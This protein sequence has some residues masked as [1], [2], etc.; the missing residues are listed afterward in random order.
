MGDR[1][2]PIKFGP[3]WLRNMPRERTASS[4]PNS[5]NPSSATSSGGGA[6]SPG[7]SGA[8]ASGTPTPSGTGNTANNSGTSKV[9][10]AKLRYGREEMLALYDRNTEA[11]AELKAIETLYQPR[12]KPP[13][14][15]DNTFEEERDTARSVPPTGGAPS[16]ERYGMGRG[17]GRG[18]HPVEGRGR[19][20]GMFIRQT[21]TVRSSSWHVIN[22]R[23]PLYSGPEDDPVPPNRSWSASNPPNNRNSGEQT[24]WTPNKPY[25]NKRPGPNTNWRQ[26]SRDEG[27]EWRA[28]TS[29]SRGQDKWDRDWG[30]RPNQEKQSWNPNRRNWAGDDD[31]LPEWA[32]ENAEAC[33][34]TFDSSG[35]FHGYS[36]DDS[37]L[38]KNQD[39]VYRQ[40]LTR[41][42]THGSFARQ[43]TVEE[44]S[45]EWWA[46]EKAKKL[47]PK[48]F[49]AG[50]IKFK[51]PASAAIPEASANIAVKTLS[52]K[53]DQIDDEES[54]KD[55]DATVSDSPPETPKKAIVP[56]EKKED[57]KKE[58]VNKKPLPKPKFTEV[59]P[60]E[61][62]M[63]SE[64]KTKQTNEDNFKSAM[65]MPPNNNLRQKHQNIVSP[66]GDSHEKQERQPGIL[67]LPSSQDKINKSAENK[68]VDD[69]F[70][71]A[72][73]DK[74]ILQKLPKSTNSSLLAA[75][76][77]Q[78]S[79]MPGGL[80][81]VVHPRPDIHASMFSVPPPM[82]PGQG[83]AINPNKTILP[84]PNMQSGLQPGM[85]Q[86][87]IT[88][89]ALNASLGLPIARPNIGLP[90]TGVPPPM[91]S[92]QMSNTGLGGGA[93][94]NPLGVGGMQSGP[95]GLAGYQGGGISGLGTPNLV[96]NSLFMGQNSNN[97]SMSSPGDI[98]MPNHNNQSN[99]FPM[100]GLQHSGNQ[101]G[102][103]NSIY[104]SLMQHTS[105]PPPSTAHSLSD[106]WYYED[107]KKM[108]QGPFTSKEM[109]NWYRAG[110]FS[111]TLMVRRAC[112]TLMRPLGSY[113]PVVPF[114]QMDMMSYS[115]PHD[116]ML[117]P[118]SSLGLDVESLWNPPS[119]TSDMMWMQHSVNTRNE[120]RVNILPM[121]F[122]DQPSA[123]T[124][125]ALLPEEIAKEMKTEDQI[126]AQ[127]RASQNISSTQVPFLSDQAT[128]S[129]SNKSDFTQT[130]SATPTL[131]EL[132]K[133]MQKES[134][135]ATPKPTVSESSVA[136]EQPKTEKP[137]KPEA[138]ETLVTKQQQQKNPEPKAKSRNENEKNVK[139]QENNAKNKTKKSKDDKKDDSDL[140]VKDDD[141][142]LE[143]RSSEPS[144]TKSKKEEKVNKKDIE[145]E[146][147]EWI[148]EG[149]TIVKGSEKGNNKDVKRKAIEARA[150]EEAERKRKEEE[151]LAA[152][153]EKKK[154]QSEA[155][156]KQQDVQQPPPKPSTVESVAKK[157]PWSVANHTL[158][159]PNKDGLN[160]AEIQRLE[161][162]K[163]LEQMKEQQQ[164]MH[165]IAQQQAVAMAR[166]QE[167]Q[168][169]LGGWGKKKTTLP[170]GTP[171]QTLAEIQ[172]EAKKQAATLAAVAA[173]IMEEPLISNQPQPNHAPWNNSA[174]DILLGG[175]WDT[176][177][178]SQ[179]TKVEKPQAVES[180]PKPAETN[181]NKK[182]LT[183][184]PLVKKEIS[185][186]V[187]FE[188]WCTSALSSWSS[189]V[190][191]PTF[192]GFLK[193]IESPYEVKDYVKCYLGESKDLNDFSRQFLERRSK[194]LRVGMVTPSDDLCSPAIAINPR[195]NSGSDYQEVKGK[196]KKAK[197]NK[198]L[199]V[200]A[201]ILGFSV[202]AS[203]D[204]INVGDIDTV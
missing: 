26:S 32:M 73:E 86:V 78:S 104:N 12:G 46:S 13:A 145:K 49:D 172:A 19:G 189:K 182:K 59:K 134:L 45:E 188:N 23:M 146:K 85:I 25:R 141:V 53:D 8:T 33:G 149:F 136:V 66:V 142:K 91:L 163:K 43:K 135:I 140:K 153:E 55:S 80:S 10:L 162:E 50:D 187:E 99:M 192:V 154:K 119:S 18:H 176:P 42:H 108:I 7:A 151:K 103:F 185:P 74:D 52:A 97:S 148:K 16:G 177:Q 124:P 56:K 31:N 180:S 62:L 200:D 4:P 191:V 155:I 47:S 89:N 171:S 82:L 202:T 121:S 160:L 79:M 44:G 75:A 137:P 67:R 90:I 83:M 24:D 181:K 117:N 194:L 3:L 102:T 132:Q 127:L 158:H 186:A 147:K 69:L 5:Q 1:S 35:A 157:A 156:K 197:K 165:I 87:G 61:S 20:R 29:R 77:Q 204:R 63:R 166:D 92:N 173:S 30:E 17:A 9:L 126:L 107:P 38:P 199:K 115:N 95:T 130:T 118:Q 76:N 184:V 129:T 201:R 88:N 100:H 170:I 112:D 196:G 120:N 71:L 138:V 101:A 98:P 203:E 2:N 116:N 48:R 169:G 93:L 41:S 28:D 139:K 39:N 40:S 195:T 128:T 133:L 179:P 94:Q 183:F 51:K 58:K 114:A 174:N 105:V 96:N 60:F 84:P 123:I 68:I 11:P 14:A 64:S 161:R 57:E 131:E 34:G 110:F 175:F 113:G 37:N 125:H 150:V 122:W 15:L 72:L 111:S 152:D 143:K 144:P 6:T 178:T 36:N 159:A 198:M 164:M 54:E 22:P 70:D 81:A 168:A 27:D 167:M 109:Y 65:M 106:Q 190:D 193:D 21:P